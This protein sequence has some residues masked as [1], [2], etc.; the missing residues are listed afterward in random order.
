MDYYYSYVPGRLR[1]ETPFIR[2]NPQNAAIVEKNVKS[3]EGITSVETNPLTGS[4]L[5]LFDENKIKHERIIDFLEKQ[6]YF[7]LSKAKT[8]D[9][10]IEQATEK[11]L[12]VAEKIVVD[13][14]EDGLGEV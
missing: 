12:D 9:E 3:L 13:S 7:I 4:A 11:V 2:D 1:I 6:G 14:V 5:I 8:S 10:V